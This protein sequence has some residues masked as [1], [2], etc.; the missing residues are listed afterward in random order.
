MNLKFWKKKEP[1]P[2]KRK[3]NCEFCGKE[4]ETDSD[5]PVIHIVCD[6]AR[7]ALHEVEQKR[8]AEERK[9]IDLIKRAIRELEEESKSSTP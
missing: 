7:R 5:G 2:P 4:V 9:Q 6:I 3:A 8:L 1:S